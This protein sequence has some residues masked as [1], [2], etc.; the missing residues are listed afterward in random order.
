MAD[1]VTWLAVKAHAEKEIE[2]NR[3]LLEGV[4]P[5]TLSTIQARIRVWREVIELPSTLAPPTDDDTPAAYN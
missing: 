3:D 5:D 1:S 4:K 2:R